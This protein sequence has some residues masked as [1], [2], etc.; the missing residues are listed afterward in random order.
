MNPSA[1]WPSLIALVALASACERPE[2]PTY[3]VR[4]S[5]GVRIVESSTPAWS[6][7]QRWS[8]A[9]EPHLDI[10]ALDGPP[11]LSFDALRSVLRLADS[12]IVVAD[13]GSN[14]VRFFDGTGE[15]LHTFGASGQGPGEFTLMRSVGVLADS[16]WVYDLQSN[17]LTVID[18]SSLG[19]RVSPV[20]A[21]RLGLG[22][23]GTLA[24]GS[25]I[26]ASELTFASGPES[27]PPA[28]MQRGRAA[29]L[30][31][32]ASGET[33]DTVVVAAGSD[34][35]IRLGA[36]FIEAIRP[37]FGR[38]VSHALRGDRLLFGDQE[39]YEIRTYELDGA[40]VEIHRRLGLDLAVTDADRS[41]ALEEI[42]ADAAEDRRP[43]IR[44]RYADMQTPSTRPAF[45][46]FL[47]DPLDHLWVQDFVQGVTATTW[48][49][50]APDGVWL[51]E[52]SFPERFQPMQILEDEV[53]G[54]WRDELFVEYVRAYAL[55]RG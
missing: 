25:L 52:V 37:L 22:A 6:E 49:V 35:F 32:T 16:I 28:G 29:Y 27:P 3:A 2:P 51:G 14:E 54:V 43:Q 10:G 36:D 24:D 1:R 33:I 44:A 55:A 45:T 26:F 38:S 18:P 19:F 40:L 20:E 50:F 9:A 41:A 46:A 4:D 39:H 15:F 11:E 30:H 21:Q 12:M 17:R 48:S 5:A 23:A 42:V 34:L 53:V 47:V 13:W 8:V 7:E 31:V